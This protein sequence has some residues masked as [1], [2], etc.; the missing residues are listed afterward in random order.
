MEQLKASL[1]YVKK[2]IKDG[3]GELTETVK[4]NKEQTTKEK[5]NTPNKRSIKVLLLMEG[6]I[7]PI[8]LHVFKV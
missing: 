7:E 3:K 6:V 4:K 5:K 1:K 8:D 2:Q